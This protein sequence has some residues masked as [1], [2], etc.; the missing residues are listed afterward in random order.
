MAVCVGDPDSL[1]ERVLLPLQPPEAVHEVV[2][3]E[4]QVRVALCPAVML[5]GLAE[6]ETVGVGVG[7]VAALSTLTWTESETVPPSPE[8]LRA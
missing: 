7:V 2:L 4:L 1:P 8:Q 6:S 3:V 5:V